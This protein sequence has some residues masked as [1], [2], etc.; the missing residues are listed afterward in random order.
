[1]DNGRPGKGQNHA[2]AMKSWTLPR[3]EK[4]ERH[5]K[6]W[7]PGKG[8]AKR[9]SR[10]S[11]RGGR[12][13]KSSKK[14]NPTADVSSLF[15]RGRDGIQKCGRSTK[16]K[17]PIPKSSFRSTSSGGGRKSARSAGGE[18]MGHNETGGKGGKADDYGEPARSRQVRK[19]NREKSGGKKLGPRRP[20]QEAPTEVINPPEGMKNSL[21]GPSE[22]KTRR[23]RSEERGWTVRQKVSFLSGII[24]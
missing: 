1:M 13:P 5:L 10:R 6:N 17:S 7:R 4:A 20:I 15:P 22:G 19:V 8:K 9:G 14:E 12:L 21:P 3:R 24:L 2:E 11:T 16:K 23:S 18:G